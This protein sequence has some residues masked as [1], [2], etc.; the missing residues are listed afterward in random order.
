MVTNILQFLE[1]GGSIMWVILIMGFFALAITVERLVF[2]YKVCP[3]NAEGFLNSIVYALDNNGIQQALEITQ[4]GNSPIHRICRQILIEHQA[5]ISKEQIQSHLE[6]SSIQEFARLS[7]RVNYLNLLAN[8]ATLAGLLGTIFGLQSSF[9]ALELSQ[10]A[11]K[12]TALAR[13]IAQAMNTTAM[14]L[15][16]AIPCMVAFTQVSNIQIK[17]TDDIDFVSGSLLNHLK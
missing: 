17:R 6:Q 16:V 5:G 11:E 8:I 15:I 2:Y 14:G 7:R 10:G 9:S 4:K 1:S 12:A 3:K 13:G